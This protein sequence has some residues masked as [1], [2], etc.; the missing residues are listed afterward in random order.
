MF[1]LE[2][3]GAQP[4][5]LRERVLYP[6]ETMTVGDC[7]FISE[8]RKA[9]SARVAAIQFV[10]RRGLDWKFSMQKSR[11]GWRIQRIR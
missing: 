10:K 5:L 4:P 6:F 2:R 11:D 3:A 8:F 7:L 9:E 1:T